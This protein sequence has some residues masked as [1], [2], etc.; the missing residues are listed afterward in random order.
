VPLSDD[1]AAAIRAD[2][3]AR[4]RQA[5]Q[6]GLQDAWKRLHDALA[7]VAERLSDPEAIFRDSLIGNLRELCDVLPLLNFADNPDLENA[8]KAVENKLAGLD[9]EALRGS[10]LFRAPTNCRMC[11]RHLRQYLTRSPGHVRRRRL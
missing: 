7:H 10:S 4:T 3:D 8:R 1:E 5:L 2:I 6:E 11:G 9:P